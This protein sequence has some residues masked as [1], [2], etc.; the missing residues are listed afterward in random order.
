MELRRVNSWHKEND[1]LV[2]ELEKGQAEITFVEDD[3]LR[4]RYTEENVFSE[5]EGYILADR[6]KQKKFK[7][8]H[9]SNQL[10]IATEKLKV[11]IYLEP[12]R[13]IAADS[14]GNKIIST[15]S[16]FLTSNNQN[17]IARF[18]LGEEEKIYGLGQDPMANLNQRDKERRMWHQWG[19][20][21]RSGSGGI[22][23]MLS[24][25]GY[26]ILL[27]SSWSSRFAIGKAEVAQFNRMGDIMAPAPWSWY[28]DSGETEADTSAILLD[29]GDLDI[30]IICRNKFDGIIKGYSKLTGFA[31]MLPKWAYGFIQ[32][33][34]RY[35]SQEELLKVARTMRKKKMP[36]DGLV[37]DWLWFEEF[38]DLQ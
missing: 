15:T 18:N 11:E 4:F 8:A 3:V 23:F 19:S 12:F 10:L 37:I 1:S 25:R 32:C 26:G 7:L 27:N 35:G 13:I 31:P 5:D 29:G 33:K 38:G 24:T 16:K 2:L 28:E 17:K 14:V 34:N 6:P 30:F 36:C 22:P 20:N 21:G 9:S